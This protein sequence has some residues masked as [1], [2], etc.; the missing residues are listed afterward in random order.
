[1]SAAAYA[2]VALLSVPIVPQLI[3]VVI[4]FYALPAAG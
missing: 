2:A 1:L 3:Y 4:A